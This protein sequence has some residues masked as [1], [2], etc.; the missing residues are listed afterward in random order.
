MSFSSVPTYIIIHVPLYNTV[1]DKF[2]THITDRKSQYSALKENNI[3]RNQES[4]EKNPQ[5]YKI[6]RTSV[7]A[8]KYE[9]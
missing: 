6:I 3:T 7:R 2:L 5:A 1:L 8:A 9:K 4:V